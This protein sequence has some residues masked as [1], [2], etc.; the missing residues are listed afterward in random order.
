MAPRAALAEHSGRAVGLRIGE[1]AV[2][3]GRARWLVPLRRHDY[4]R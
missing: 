2:P 1:D 4:G 3:D